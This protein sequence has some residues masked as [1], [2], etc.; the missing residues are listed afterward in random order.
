MNTSL[1]EGRVAEWHSLSLTILWSGGADD[2]LRW[3]DF[4]ILKKKNYVIDLENNVYVNVGL[5]W[6]HDGVHGAWP[7]TLTFCC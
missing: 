7:P 1:M 2:V 6:R 3:F 4:K 5:V